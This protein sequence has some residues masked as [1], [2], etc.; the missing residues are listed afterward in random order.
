MKFSVAAALL[1]CAACASTQP[2]TPPP[3]EQDINATVLAVYNVI[4]G[5]AEVYRDDCVAGRA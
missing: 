4:S 5:P 3:E 1:L 2:P